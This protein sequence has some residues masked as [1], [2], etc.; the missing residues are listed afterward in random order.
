MSYRRLLFQ[1]LTNNWVRQQLAAAA[2]GAKI[3]GTALSAAGAAGV[4]ARVMSAE[5]VELGALTLPAARHP[6][7]TFK[8]HVQ[9][10]STTERSMK[11]VVCEDEFVACEEQE[12]GANEARP[13]ILDKDLSLQVLLCGREAERGEE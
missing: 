13:I 4:R 3:P 7:Q 12:L 9:D 11:F 6:P 1:L 8:R 2:D 5:A 10:G